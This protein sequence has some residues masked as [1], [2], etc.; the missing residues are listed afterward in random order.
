METE[1]FGQSDGERTADKITTMTGTFIDRIMVALTNNGM[2]LNLSI[3]LNSSCY[4]IKSDR[5]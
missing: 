1:V 2:P 5:W 4:K 3:E